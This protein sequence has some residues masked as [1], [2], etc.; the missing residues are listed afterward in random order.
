MVDLDQPNHA[1]A[2]QECYQKYVLFAQFLLIFMTYELLSYSV[3][4]HC[5]NF[6]TSL[7]SVFYLYDF[8]NI[9]TSQPDLFG[10]I[11]GKGHL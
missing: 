7:P 6:H 1:E 8:Q 9:K 10:V 11:L 2:C 5:A 4:L 3:R